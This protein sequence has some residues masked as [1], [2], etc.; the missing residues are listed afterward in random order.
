[1]SKVVGKL[2]K[3]ALWKLIYL[4][5]YLKEIKKQLHWTIHNPYYKRGFLT[6]INQRTI[7][8][9]TIFLWLRII[10]VALVLQWIWYYNTSWVSNIDDL[11]LVL[12]FYSKLLSVG[13]F[14]WIKY[15]F[16]SKLFKRQAPKMVKCTQSIREIEA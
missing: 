11:V 2:R 3:R 6:I 8:V 1:M 5:N 10:I 16:V 9:F 14:A 7:G 12:T 15:L 4:I 13:D